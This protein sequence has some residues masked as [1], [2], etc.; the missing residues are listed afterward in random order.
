MS[1]STCSGAGGAAASETASQIQ[2]LLAKK[3]LDA[4]KTQGDAMVQLLEGI[5][6]GKAPGKGD[7]VDLSA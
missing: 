3:Q 1:C 6:Q 5:A 7:A 4:M 2:M